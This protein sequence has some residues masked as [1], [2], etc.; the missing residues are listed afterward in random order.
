MYI[1]PGHTEITRSSGS[2]I[3]VTAKR[4]SYVKR[5]PGA[6][7]DARQSGILGMARDTAGV[8]YG[9]WATVAGSHFA[10]S[11]NPFSHAVWNP[12]ATYTPLATGAG[13]DT[14]NSLLTSSATLTGNRSTETLKIAPDSPDQTFSL[15]SHTLTLNTGG[16]LVP[17]GNANPFN[18]TGGI[19]RGAHAADLI[20]HQHGSADL[21]VSSTIADHGGPTALTKTG[22]GTLVLG[23]ANAYTGDTFLNQGTLRLASPAALPTTTSLRFNGGILDLAGHSIIIESLTGIGSL[24]NSGSTTAT[25]TTGAT[26]AFTLAPGQSLD[27]H[28]AQNA[29]AP[30][31]YQLWAASHGLTAGVNDAATDDADHD[32]ITN[33]VEYALGMNPRISDLPPGTFD[34]STLTFTKG[35]DAL[36]NGDVAYAIE[37]SDDL[38]ITDPWEEVAATEMDNTISHTFPPGRSRVFARLKA[39]LSGPAVLR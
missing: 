13:T 23:G 26:T 35:A 21:T 6:T 2:S 30:N 22:P 16:L 14:D 15:A 33:L 18:V 36:A 17:D 24:Q 34:G 39:A 12:L 25:I 9:G 7:V 11:S 20:I 5:S 19:L 31:S 37:E 8:P 4:F 10:I 3:L 1:R 38:G 32:G 28:V 27:T 29:V